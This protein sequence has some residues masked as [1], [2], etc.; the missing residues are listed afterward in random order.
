MNGTPLPLPGMPKPPKPVDD[1]EEWVKAVWPAFVRAADSG[2]PFTT[3]EIAAREKLPDPVKSQA[4]WGKL[5]G[6]LQKAGLIEEYY[7][8]GKSSR[9]GVNGSLVHTWI[10][11]PAHRRAEAAA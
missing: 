11:I 7:R 3:S 2:Q 1:F 8:P 6:R 10:G 4:Q 5:P 9:R